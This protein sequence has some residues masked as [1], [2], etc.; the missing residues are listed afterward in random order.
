MKKL[1]CTFILLFVF[2]FCNSQNLI[3]NGDFEQYTICPTGQGQSNNATGYLALNPST[4]ATDYLNTC[5]TNSG[6][7]VPVNNIGYQQAHSGVAYCGIFLRQYTNN[8]REYVE[9]TFSSPLIAGTCYRFEMYV[10]LGD[11]SMYTSNDIGVYFTSNSITGAGFAPLPVTPQISNMSATLLDSMNWTLL[12]GTFTATGGENYFIVGNFLFDAAMTEQIVNLSGYDW[13]Y[14]YVD[15]V[16]LTVCTEVEENNT[17]LISVFPSLFKNE[18]IISGI[19][20]S[21]S[22]IL[23]DAAGKL[24]LSQELN[25][26][27]TSVNTESLAKGFYFYEIRNK[28]GLI[29]KGKLVKN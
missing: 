25:M 26:Q 15:D 9:G 22:I 19:E 23:C 18:L 14:V 16:S 27:N 3:I 12:S 20:N 17:N 6:S 8:I 28:A 10:N 2:V 7:D 29:K 21:V 24:V 5:S 1:I 11:N 4:A 13:I